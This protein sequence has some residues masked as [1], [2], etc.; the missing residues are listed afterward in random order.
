MRD[1]VKWFAEGMER[2]LKKRDGYGGW[3]HLPLIYLKEKLKAEINELMI[4]M[5]YESPEEVIDES[6]DVANF[7]MMIADI[8]ENELDT[9]AGLVR[10]GKRDV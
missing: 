8:M 1:E 2:K 6:I 9:R 7:A 4:A 5:D 10:R 3:R